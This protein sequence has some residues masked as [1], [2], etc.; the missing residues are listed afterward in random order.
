M[1]TASEKRLS[2]VHPKLAEKV[3][4]AV[5]ALQAVNGIEVR[6]VQGLCTYAEQDAL[7][8]QGRLRKGPIVTN[9]RGGYSNHNFGLAVDLCPFK[10]GKPLWNSAS[11]F[12]L[13]GMRAEEQGLEWGGRWPRFPDRPH[14]QLKGTPELK[15]CRQLFGQG[16]LAK[17]WAAV[18][19]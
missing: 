17:V 6:V 3:R 18:R 10:D 12:D 8:A 15:V 7:Y 19:T 9:A 5:T 13:I 4:A 16:G 11:G 1:D 2:Q 14:V